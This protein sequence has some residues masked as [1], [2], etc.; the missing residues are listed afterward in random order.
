MLAAANRK[1]DNR[2]TDKFRR[3]LRLV[4]V[5]NPKGELVCLDEL[6]IRNGL[7]TDG[8]EFYYSSRQYFKRIKPKEKPDDPDFP[9][10]NLSDKSKAS[11]QPETNSDDVIAEVAV[12][13]L[14]RSAGS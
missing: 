3:Q 2:T 6:L 14:H 5:V 9:K 12:E 11:K 4:C 13:S 8:D 1:T 10:D 7:A